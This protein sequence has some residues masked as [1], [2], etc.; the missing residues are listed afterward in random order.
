MGDG[1]NGGQIKA[2]FAELGKQTV[3]GMAKAASDIA[4]GTVETVMK[5]G[6]PQGGSMVEKQQASQVGSQDPVASKIQEKSEVARRRQLAYVRQQ[7]EAFRQR[8][9]QQRAQE[10]QV[11]QKEE[12]EKLQIKQS[13]KAQDDQAF[14]ARLKRAYGGTHEGDNKAL[15]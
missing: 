8:Q 3:G 14:L 9:G 13:K 10:Q 5:G 6:L 2:D 7:L 4:G 12:T 1:S 15:G 11:K